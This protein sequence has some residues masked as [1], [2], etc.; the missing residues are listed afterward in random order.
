[1]SGAAAGAGAGAGVVVAAGGGAAG[2]WRQRVRYYAPA[3]IVFVGAIVAWELIVSAL[4][5]QKFILP[6]PTAIVAALNEN[7]TSSRFNLLASAQATLVEALGGLAIGTVAGVAV[8]FATARWATARGVLLPLAIAA[9]AV[10]IIAFAP[11]LNNW[12]GLEN[13]LSK[14]VMAA[15][16]VFFPV[17]ANV[18]RGLVQVDPAALELMRASAA[19]EWQVLRKVRIPNALPYFFTAMK[20]ATT[21]SLIGAIV[22]EYFGGASLVL[23]RVIV[24]SS[25]ALRFDVTWAAILLAAATGIVFYLAIVAIERI[26]IPWHASMR[27]TEGT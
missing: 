10:P 14:M 2:R 6:K 16:L 13:P 24:Q 22:A 9:N 11:I 27:A 7:L 21:L 19:T 12:F 25:S 15:V 23:G 4:N 18:T 5:L 3:V 20:L 26:V 8:A 17:M 1:M